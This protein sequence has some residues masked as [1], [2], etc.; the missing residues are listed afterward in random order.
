LIAHQFQQSW[1]P[2]GRFPPPN[3]SFAAASDPRR[4]SAL[5]EAGVDFY[6]H[7]ESEFKGKSGSNAGALNRL[8][9]LLNQRILST[10]HCHDS[11]AHL[12]IKDNNSVQKPFGTQ[13][14]KKVWNTG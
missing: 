11:F 10:I 1:R 12:C 6:F 8:F 4:K 2:A 13:F 9:V 5:P 14:F 7:E 3:P